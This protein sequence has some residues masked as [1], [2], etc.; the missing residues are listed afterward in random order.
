MHPYLYR[1][2]AGVFRY[3]GENCVMFLQTARFLM[4]SAA[5][6][7]RGD[8]LAPAVAHLATLARV[9]SAAGK[10]L[11]YAAPLVLGADPTET[12][13]SSPDLLVTLFEVGCA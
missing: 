2:A 13:A 1:D 8:A 10:V 3:E 7:M 6:A 11:P 9:D 5:A 12:L 4:K